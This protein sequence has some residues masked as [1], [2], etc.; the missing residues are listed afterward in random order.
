MESDDPEG[1]GPRT[2]CS[3]RR[4]R[5]SWLCQGGTRTRRIARRLLG[6]LQGHVRGL[7]SLWDTDARLRRLELLNPRPGRRRQINCGVGWV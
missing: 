4:A 1:M 3:R 5:T 2:R 7:G 6:P